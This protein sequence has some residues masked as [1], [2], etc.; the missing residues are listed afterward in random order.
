MV[1]GCF[2]GPSSVV[3]WTDRSWN[4]SRRFSHLQ[5]LTHQ[6]WDPLHL[7]G[8]SSR[9]VAFTSDLHLASRLRL[10]GGY[11]SCLFTAGVG[12][13][14]PLSFTGIVSFDDLVC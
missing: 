6:L 12:Q 3:G 14:L 1:A 10:S 11:L 7:N 9:S 13:L 8:K 4:P 2:T 5:T